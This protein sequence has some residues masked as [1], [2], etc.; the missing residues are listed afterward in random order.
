MKRVL[1]VFFLIYSLFSIFIPLSI[2]QEK[3]ESTRY[4]IELTPLQ[5]TSSDDK[6]SNQYNMLTEDEQIEFERSGIVIRNN[7][8]NNSFGIAISSNKISFEEVESQSSTN[9]QSLDIKLI[10]NTNMDGRVVIIQDQ[11]LTHVTANTPIPN[12]SCDLDSCSLSK[13]QQWQD[14]SNIGYGYNISSKFAP[15][16]FQNIN[17]Y[18]PL[19]SINRKESP[20]TILS[21]KIPIQTLDGQITFKF[22]K[23]RTFIE[24]T[25]VHNLYIIAIPVY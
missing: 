4:K 10:S 16:D 14:S 15:S 23:S 5:D 11:L 20:T 17:M 19:P 2:A 24:G 3:Q 22:I 9:M 21:T 25:Y 8:F 13:S 7:S 1:I 6:D 18:R 12:T